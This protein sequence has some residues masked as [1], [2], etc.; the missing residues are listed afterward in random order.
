MC[1]RSCSFC[2]KSD[3][4][5]APDTYQKMTMKLIDKLVS[6]LKN[7]NYQGAFC[8]CGYGEP[9]LHKKYIDIINKLGLLGGVEIVTN[10]DLVN[11]KHCW[12]FITLKQ[13]GY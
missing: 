4:K 13:Q 11:K 8:L 2:P 3:P 6:D 5:I 1:N 7:I 10:G 12:K 9:M